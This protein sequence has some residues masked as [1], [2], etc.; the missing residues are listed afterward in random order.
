MSNFEKLD[1]FLVTF[2]KLLQ[3]IFVLDINI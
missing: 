3:E 2:G 1:N